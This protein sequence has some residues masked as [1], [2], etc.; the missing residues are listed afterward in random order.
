MSKA[1]R[2]TM[3][4]V[5]VGE[6]EDAR[7]GGGAPR[8]C[9]AGSRGKA[10][11]GAAA[12]SRSQDLAERVGF[13]PTGPRGPAVFK[14]AP[15][16]R[17]GTSPR[18]LADAILP[19]G[20]GSGCHGISRPVRGPAGSDQRG[21]ASVPGSATGTQASRSVAGSATEPPS[22]TRAT[23][24]RRIPVGTPT[25]LSIPWASPARL[26]GHGRNAAV[27]PAALAGRV[28]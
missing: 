22:G 9:H 12:R 18:P 19:P 5:I 28:E 4:R 11:V 6:M 8:G 13:E 24:T 25:T 2:R 23:T 10:S 16:D 17:S 3:G 7:R 14:T 15:I 1:G 20:G 27:G 21:V 26:F